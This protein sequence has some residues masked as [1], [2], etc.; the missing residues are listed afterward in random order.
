[1]FKQQTAACLGQAATRRC[2][3]SQ[4]TAHQH[5]ITATSTLTD[6]LCTLSAANLLSAGLPEQALLRTSF[7]SNSM[8][9]EAK[10]RQRLEKAYSVSFGLRFTL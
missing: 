1:M 7:V 5:R 3:S 9:E 10:T 4:H 6:S 8:G 2:T